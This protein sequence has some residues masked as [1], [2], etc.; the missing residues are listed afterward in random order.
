[1]EVNSI[2]RQ[3]RDMALF[4]YNASTIDE[5][6]TSIS[7]IDS[8]T[9]TIR[10]LYTGEDGLADQYIQEVKDWESVFGDISQALQA[11]N[12]A[13]V[14]QLIHPQAEPGR[15]HRPVPHSAAGHPERAAH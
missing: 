8:T 6:E 4:G 3:L 15:I 9:E 11:G 13:Q 7:T 12:S 5:I 2:A 1:M 10:T 14:N